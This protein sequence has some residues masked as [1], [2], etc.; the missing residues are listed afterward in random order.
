MMVLGELLLFVLKLE[1]WLKRFV[2]FERNENEGPFS[3]K[4]P[5]A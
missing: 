3:F 2:G 4:R 1:T 5:R